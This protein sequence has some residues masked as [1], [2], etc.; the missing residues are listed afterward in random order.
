MQWGV[1]ERHVLSITEEYRQNAVDW[2]GE[3]E[4]EG[5]EMRGGRRKRKIERNTVETRLAESLIGEFMVFTHTH[6]H[7]QALVST[8]LDR[9]R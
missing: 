9:E 5:A 4:N 3:N 1:I 6:K 7:V 8:A 2:K